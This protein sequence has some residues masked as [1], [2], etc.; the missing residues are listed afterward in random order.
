MSLAATRWAWAQRVPPSAK[1]VLL[2]LAD[3]VHSRG[4]VAVC[5]PSVSR[6]ARMTGLGR[7]TVYKALDTLEAAGLVARLPGRKGRTTVY[8]LRLASGEAG[9]VAEPA[10]AAQEAAPEPPPEPAAPAADG[11]AGEAPQRSGQHRAGELTAEQ[12]GRFRGEITVVL[13]NHGAYPVDI[14]AG[15]PVAQLLIVP[16]AAAGVVA[17]VATRASTRSRR[18]CSAGRRSSSGAARSWRCRPTSRLGWW[19]RSGSSPT[20]SSAAPGARASIGTGSSARC[21]ARDWAVTRR[22]THK[23]RS[24]F[25]EPER[26]LA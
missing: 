1:L 11:A 4:Q 22:V 15:E 26:P 2:A 18:R 9:A 14:S 23:P 5:W 19:S 25:G 13:H 12:E 10:P 17:D 21:G 3:C 7:R 8:R 6:V 20:A 16:L 24:L